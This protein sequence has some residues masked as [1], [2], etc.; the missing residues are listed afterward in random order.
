MIIRE[1]VADDL[2]ALLGLYVYLKKDIELV[3]DGQIEGIWESILA[4]RNH[5]VIIGVQNDE[6][7]SSCVLLVVPNLTHEHR[8]YALI[9]NVVTHQA[10]R[11]KGYASAILEYAKAVA[12]GENCYKI[13]LLTGSKEKHVHQLYEKAGYNRLDK[14]AYIQWLS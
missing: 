7:V 13:M 6:L 8:P 12:M 4:D 9:E 3:V 10:H 14:T 1:A 5:H 11:G 2:E